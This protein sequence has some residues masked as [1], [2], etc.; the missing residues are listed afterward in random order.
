M[1]GMNDRAQHAVPAL[2]SGGTPHSGALRKLPRAPA[3]RRLRRR[4]PPTSGR[5]R[6][7]VEAEPGKAQQAQVLARR[8]GQKA[9]GDPI[10]DL[11]PQPLQAAGHPA[12]RGR[13]RWRSAVCRTASFA[14]P[15]AGRRRRGSPGGQKTF[16]DATQEPGV[17]AVVVVGCVGHHA[18]GKTCQRLLSDHLGRL[19][20]RYGRGRPVPVRR[21]PRRAGGGAQNRPGSTAVP[22]RQRL[23]GPA[24]RR[25]SPPRVPRAGR[26]PPQVMKYWARLST[27]PMR[28][29]SAM[30][31]RCIRRACT[32]RKALLGPMPGTR[33]S[34][35]RAAVL[36]STGKNSGCRKAHVHL[37][38]R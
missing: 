31:S 2:R 13:G 6:G 3:R 36:T 12:A 20:G 34:S 1:F 37:G 5:P 19:P 30:P 11:R 38:S 33:S 35:S 28:L 17:A 16:K 18:P 27:T 10:A 25:R 4:R 8:G 7:A 21:G 29:S 26:R 32:M 22:L 14:P 9:G 23:L 24:A 15:G